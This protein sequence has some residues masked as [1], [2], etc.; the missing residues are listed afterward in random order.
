MI[1]S[2]A[3]LVILNSLQIRTSLSMVDFLYPPFELELVL[4]IVCNMPIIFTVIEMRHI[5]PMG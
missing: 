4:S 1:L 3:M 2:F 5:T